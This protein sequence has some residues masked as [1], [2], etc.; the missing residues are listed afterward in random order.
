M[1][2]LLTAARM[3]VRITP[4]YFVSPCGEGNAGSL[5]D[6]SKTRRVLILLMS[7]GRS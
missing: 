1:L 7:G 2:T 3:P 4:F 6:N 5:Q